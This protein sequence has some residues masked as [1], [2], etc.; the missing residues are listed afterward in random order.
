MR[1]KNRK[2]IGI[3]KILVIFL[4]MMIVGIFAF[5]RISEKRDNES[6]NGR[7]Q[8]YKT[9][10]NYEYKETIETN[11]TV[12]YQY[13]K[14]ECL[15]TITTLSDVEDSTI[16][17]KSNPG[18]KDGWSYYSTYGPK[19]DLVIYK[20][21]NIKYAKDE[22]VNLKNFPYDTSSSSVKVTDIPIK[23]E[24]NSEL[25]NVEYK[26][27]KDST[28]KTIS[29]D[30]TISGKN[31]SYIFG[32]IDSTYMA[33]EGW[34]MGDY[35][36]AGQPASTAKKTFTSNDNYYQILKFTSSDSDNAVIN[37]NIDQIY[38]ETDSKYFTFELNET[39]KTAKITGIKD[40]YAEKGYYLNYDNTLNYNL[41]YNCAIKDGTTFITDIVIP[42]NFN[43]YTVIEIGDEA[44]GR[45]GAGSAIRN[46]FMFTSFLL[47]ETI[48]KIGNSA[49]C[50]CTKVTKIN[51][52]NS[53]TSIGS[54]A[55]GYCSGLTNIIIPS[56]VTSIGSDAFEYCKG[57]TNITI[58]SSVTSIG[59]Y[60]FYNCSGLT[61]ITIPSNVTSIGN[62]VFLG[63][64]ELTNINVDKENKNYSDDNGILFN[65]D[66]T[67]MIK[68]PEGKKKNEYIIPNS[69]TS[70]ENRALENC[71][72]LM[73]ITIPG[74][75]TQ[76]GYAAFSNWT[77]NQTIDCTDFDSVPS[78]WDKNWNSSCKATIK[79]KTAANIPVTGITLNKTNTTLAINAKETLTAMVSPTNAT[80]KEITW[81]SSNQSIVTVNNGEITAKG[82]G[83]AKITATTKDG[84]K[85]ASCT[86]VVTNNVTGITIKTAPTKVIYNKGESLNLTG[87][88]ITITRQSGEKQD[89]DITS[90]MVSGYNSSKTG[91]QTITVTYEGKT[92][93]FE[94]TVNE[95]TNVSV[96]GISL[97]KTTVEIKV[98]EWVI[99][100]ATITPSNATDKNIIWSSSDGGIATVINGKITAVKEGTAT[101]TAKT[102]DGGKVATCKVNV[103]KNENP[104]PSKQ[105]INFK[106]DIPEQIVLKQGEEF[107]IPNGKITL[108]YSDG[109]TQEILLTKEELNKNGVTIEYD[110][111]KLG[112]Q[113]VV[114]HYNERTFELEVLVTEDGKTDSTISVTGVQLSK[115]EITL[116]EG[117][118]ETLEYTITPENA[119][120]K[121]VSWSSSDET[122]ATVRNG[123]ITAIKKGETTITVTTEDGNKTATCT[124]TVE[125]TQ[126]INNGNGSNDNNNYGD[127]NV[128][129]GG[130][131]SDNTL[132]PSS[133]TANPTVANTV[134]P[135]TGIGRVAF[136]A[137]IIIGI[138]GVVSISKYKKI[139]R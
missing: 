44:F 88:K 135:K 19:Y 114:F 72:G 52:P 48:T 27:N 107:A 45:I 93:S 43:G 8:N 47:P 133:N 11:T 68:C 95:T 59:S 49:F 76:I 92:T 117:D 31:N 2:K 132:I 4:I 41:K 111:T 62:Y 110:K 109:T 20:S 18:N 100:E 58:P 12:N 89:I 16:P 15:V 64:S 87:G 77:E 71:S 96:T 102:N 130:N 119:T 74:S 129:N 116:K 3:I 91:K 94:I 79:W 126:D 36:G 57:L 33:N 34:T 105:I 35:L 23:I 125:K 42:S 69:V 51:I 127:N 82:V 123:M 40:E 122:V 26:Y 120:N 61:N 21:F 136:L 85:V 30:V 118:T 38:E 65:K 101:I 25:Y 50:G 75:V 84:N 9:S 73:N 1:R 70:I 121:N 67:I 103:I 28:G 80:N 113:K 66:K 134:L 137:I 29:C 98:G 86:V 99:V 22:I 124:V 128:I 108:Y 46:N 10:Y 17:S 81:A 37:I 32:N 6:F 78:G 13:T 104:T 5:S 112:K 54:S 106:L 14:N 115:N 39:N 53:V 55:F 63:C 24:R 90:S 7:V 139:D 131:N 83:T 97:D 138:V 56:G 60:A